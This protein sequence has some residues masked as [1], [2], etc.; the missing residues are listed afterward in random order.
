MHF[1]QTS[2]EMQFIDAQNVIRSKIT[3]DST[4]GICIEDATHQFY[5]KSTLSGIE[6]VD[7]QNNGLKVD[8]GGV[9]INSVKVEDFVI[10]EGTSGSWRYRK[11]HS[12]KIEAWYEGSF[13][14]AAST[15]ARGALYYSSWSLTI[16]SA[17]GFTATPYTLVGNTG[18]STTVISVNGAATSKT[19]MSG[20]VWRYASSSSALSITARIYAWQN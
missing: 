13:N 6:L 19:A 16:P 7:D 2:T 12:G 11:W 5:I 18:S 14:C 17:I 9:Y 20:Y 4:N 1:V 8:G 3:A 10:D 15:T